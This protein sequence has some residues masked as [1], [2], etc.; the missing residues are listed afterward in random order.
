MQVR[1]RSVGFIKML[2]GEA[3]FDVSLP[4]DATLGTLLGQ[5]AVDKGGMFARFASNTSASGESVALRAV[6]NGRDI[7]ALQGVS[8]VLYEGDD[9]LLF[10]PIAGG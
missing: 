2:L 8:T 5:L 9:V 3:E 7:T 6:V 1:V 4:D 10:F